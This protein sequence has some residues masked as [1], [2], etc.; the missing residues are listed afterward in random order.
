MRMLRALE[1]ESER[2]LLKTSYKPI[3]TILY[4]P[5]RSCLD[6]E[7]RQRGWQMCARKVALKCTLSDDVSSSVTNGKGCSRP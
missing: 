3:K 2:D 4:R 7:M 1:H 5:I 6:I